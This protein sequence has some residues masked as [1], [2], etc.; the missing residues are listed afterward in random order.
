MIIQVKLFIQCSLIFRVS[1]SGVLWPHCSSHFIKKK[2]IFCYC[3]VITLPY[4]TVNQLMALKGQ[5]LNRSWAM[6]SVGVVFQAFL[7]LNEGCLCR[8][9]MFSS[10]III[11]KPVLCWNLAALFTDVKITSVGLSLYMHSRC[12]KNFFLWRVNCVCGSDLAGAVLCG[13]SKVWVQLSSA[14][15]YFLCWTAESYIHTKNWCFECCLCLKWLNLF[16]HSHL[17][18]T[19]WLVYVGASDIVE[20]LV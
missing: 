13:T 16:V 18:S 5:F 1:A 3:R 6:K 8:S 12:Y 4:A 2:K 17:E 10:R 19:N 15:T 7:F 20:G 14:V 11:S 9:F